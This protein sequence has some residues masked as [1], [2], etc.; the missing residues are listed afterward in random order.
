MLAEAHEL[1]TDLPVTAAA[2]SVYDEASA[3]GLGRR[4][5]PCWP[6]SGPQGA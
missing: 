6:A 3:R 4:M 1:G 2:L 5:G